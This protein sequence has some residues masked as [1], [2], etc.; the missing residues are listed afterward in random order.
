[1]AYFEVKARYEKTTESG[2]KKTVTE[3]YIVDAVSITEA[4]ARLVE[5]IKDFY[6]DISVTYVRKRNIAEVF[7]SNE[8]E[9]DRWYKVKAVF[10]SFNKNTGVEKR[11]PSL[12]LIQARDFATAYRRFTELMKDTVSDYE[13]HSITETQITE[14]YLYGNEQ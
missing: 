14:I 4:E 7:P 12:Y 9:D 1:M 3:P 11:T 10:V 8:T 6:T 2:M 5:E 13:I